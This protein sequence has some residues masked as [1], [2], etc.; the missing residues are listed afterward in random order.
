VL[1]ASWRLARQAENLAPSSLRTYDWALRAFTE[2]LARRAKTHVGQITREDVQSFIS[3]LLEARTAKTARLYATVVALFLRWCVDEGEIAV[4]PAERLRLPAVPAKVTPVLEV[5][6]VRALLKACE[7]NGFAER[8]DMA[9]LR[10]LLSTGLRRAEL[11]GLRVADVDLEQLVA[12]TI[13][14]GRREHLFPF[15]HKARLALDRYLRVRARH[16]AAAS[17]MLWLGASGTFGGHGIYHM[18]QRRAAQA[19]LGH[20]WPHLLRHT[21]AHTWLAEGGSEQGLMKNIG[22][23]SRAMLDHYGRSVAEQRARDEY[24]RLQPGDQF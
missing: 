20:I 16:P 7:G 13:I 2:H 23:R 19:G 24:Q 22:W 21:Y 6:E 10:L 3:W 17:P 5:A 9:I 4:S 1:L 15:G 8:R 18:L 12:R 11:A 14:K